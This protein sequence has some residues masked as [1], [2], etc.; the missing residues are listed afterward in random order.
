MAV[1]YDKMIPDQNTNYGE[2]RDSFMIL[3]AM[4]QFTIKRNVHWRREAEGLLRITLFSKDL[5]LHGWDKTLLSERRELAQY[6]RETRNRGVVPVYLSTVWFL[7]ALGIAIEAG[8]IG[9]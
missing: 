2:I 7:F 8:T 1:P 6:L 3:L 5:R 4:N 9:S